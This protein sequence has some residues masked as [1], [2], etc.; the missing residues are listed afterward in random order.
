MFITIIFISDEI[1]PPPSPA[2]PILTIY[3]AFT[4]SYSTAS[5]DDLSILQQVSSCIVFQRHPFWETINAA[6]LNSY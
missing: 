4:E 3:K 2:P 6:K 5:I 1:L